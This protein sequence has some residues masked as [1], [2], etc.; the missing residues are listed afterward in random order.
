[1]TLNQIR[2]KAILK[3]LSMTELATALGMNRRTLYLHI[4]R[5]EETTIK[6]IKN[7]LND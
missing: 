4:K 6:S 3:N 7:F 1:M 5:Q 2:A